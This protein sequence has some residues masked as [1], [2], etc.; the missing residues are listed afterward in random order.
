MERKKLLTVIVAVT[1]IVTLLPV[2]VFADVA[3]EASPISNQKIKEVVYYDKNPDPNPPEGWGDMPAVWVHYDDPDNHPNIE[4]FVLKEVASQEEANNSVLG[5][6]GFKINGKWYKVRGLWTVNP[7]KDIIDKTNGEKAVF[8][9]IYYAENDKPQEGEK[10]FV[11]LWDYDYTKAGSKEGDS[12][13]GIS[14]PVEITIPGKDKTTEVKVAEKETNNP[15]KKDNPMFARGK[16]VKVQAKKK[17]SFK[18]PKVIKII[19]A[20]G[21]LTF[22]KL[23]GNKKI[24]VNKKTG[25]VKVGKG[26]KKGKTYKVLIRVTAAG[27]ATYNKVS[28]IVMVK[29]KIK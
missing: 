17:A 5:Y 24:T 7:E 25:K 20:V 28:K 27:D 29:I 3:I 22:E 8:T 26:L 1:L 13:G 11:A 6:S 2:T 10:V 14:E 21:K 16:K 12:K 4:V 9:P 23:S 18:R 15:T 19:G